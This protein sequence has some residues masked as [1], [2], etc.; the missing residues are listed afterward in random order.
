MTRNSKITLRPIFLKLLRAVMRTVYVIHRMLS[1]SSIST[2]PFVK[3]MK[4]ASSFQRNN[5]PRRTTMILLTNLLSSLLTTLLSS[6]SPLKTTL[7]QLLRT[8]LIKQYL[9]NYV[10]TQQR[11]KPKSL[12]R[13]LPLMSTFTFST[14]KSIWTPTNSLRIPCVWI[15]V[16]RL[17]V[18]NACAML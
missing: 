7:S 12:S 2:T 4:K 9:K 15:S 5:K 11:M 14:T 10:W 6:F 18:L 13:T 16:Y 8:L 1:R 3:M 17:H